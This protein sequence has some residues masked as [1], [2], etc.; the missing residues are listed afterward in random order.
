M[1]KILLFITALLL[2]TSITSFASAEIIVK[3]Q[4][5]EIYNLGD[6]VNIPITIKTISGVSKV[7]EM[8]LICQDIQK[9]FYKNG[10]S[11]GP[12]EEKTINPELILTN[13][14][15]GATLGI[16][17]IKGQLGED[18]IITNEFEISNQINLQ[19]AVEVVEFNPGENI[20]IKGNAQKPNGG[21]ANGFLNIE[22][23]SGM[24]NSNDIYQLDTIG[25][26]FFSVNITFP[27][28][29]KAGAYLVKLDA[30]ELDNSG[31]KTNTGFMNYNILI[32]QI[33]TS[34]EVSFEEQEVEPGEKLKVRTIMRD[35]T[36]ERIEGGN[37]IVTI[38]KQN[39]EIVEQ[40]DIPMDE[41]YEYSISYNE[42][43]EEWKVVAVSSRITSEGTFLI[44][45]KR[46]ID[47]VI[48]NE[49]INLVNTGNVPYDGLVF[50]KIGE[51][52]LEV[53]ASLE[54]DEVQ[55]YKLTA[56]E[57]EYNIE[58]VS[59]GEQKLQA[60]VMLTGRAI[61]VKQMRNANSKSVMARPLAWIFMIMILGFIT[62]MVWKKGLKKSFFGKIRIKKKPKKTNQAWD[63]RQELVRKPTSL[64]D[65]KNK[66]FLS[67]SMK[68]E[69]HPSSIICLKIKNMQDVQKTENNVKQT[70]NKIVTFAEEQKAVIYET[71]DNIFF[72]LS[73][74][75]TKTFK[76]EANAL[77]IAEQ[78]VKEITN[79]NKLFKQLI[80]F[81]ISLNQGHI[82]TKENPE[83]KTLHFMSMGNLIAS[84]KKLSTVSSGKILISN[85]MKHRL[86]DKASFQEHKHPGMNFFTIKDKKNPIEHAKFLS[87]F[88]KR[89]EKDQAKQNQE[90]KE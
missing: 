16:C 59:D 84:S 77:E 35:Q 87:S 9:Q 27:E 50:I 47:V 78:A 36:G 44:K 63:S 32:K 70:L 20:I 86:K 22:I 31:T 62:F 54:V 90:K 57:G 8:N 61:D 80:E 60:N 37:S 81:G 41:Y 3:Q 46:N 23:L 5:N 34:L 26:G 1:K 64:I 6:S 52:T 79:H 7:F 58:V 14:M 66:A 49:T 12:G 11:L 55:K 89:M 68:G 42:A 83:D 43:P 56:P 76:N 17:K 74:T 15:I 65:T 82:V 73:P 19:T 85:E 38:K 2:I 4:P 29:M 33:P 40:I 45:E 72:I 67:L 25:N 51:E 13:E 39:N 48:I 71:Q 75:R 18:Y 88:M 53:N 24:N 69:K 28:I 21:D 10:I 30:Y